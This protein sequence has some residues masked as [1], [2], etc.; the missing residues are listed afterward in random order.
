VDE[1]PEVVGRAKPARWREKPGDL[2]APRAVKPILHDGHQL[3][4]RESLRHDVLD[5]LA[6]Q[7][8]PRQRSKPLDRIAPPRT[9]VH[10]INGEGLV[11]SVAAAR[12]SRHPRVVSPLMPSEVRG[13]GRRAR[14]SLSPE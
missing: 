3:D 1:R 4:V 14:R 5:E 12:A 9:G 10:Y 7:F 6:R 8:A 13:D 2:I 11:E